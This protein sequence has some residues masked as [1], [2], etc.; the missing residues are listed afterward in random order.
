MSIYL[1]ELTRAM[2]ELG[3]REDTLFLGQQVGAPGIRMHETFAGVPEDKKIEFPVAENLQMGVAIGLAL[4][5]F[6]PVCCFPR[7]NFML[8]AMDQLVNHLDRLPLYSDY[9]PKVIVRTAVGHNRPLDPGPQHQDDFTNEFR[10][11][12]ETVNVIKLDDFAGHA[13]EAY[14]RALNLHYSSVVIEDGN[15]Y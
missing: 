12:L 1:D 4:E 5:G 15:S 2:T 11:M 10:S 13:R 14:G 8:Y 3:R 9:R 6:L 7:M